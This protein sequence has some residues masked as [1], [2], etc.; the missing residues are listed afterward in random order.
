MTAF[1][2]ADRKKILESLT[3]EVLASLILNSIFYFQNLFEPF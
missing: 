3:S 1:S 2:E